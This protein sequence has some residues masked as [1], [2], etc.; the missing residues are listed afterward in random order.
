[1]LPLCSLNQWGN[2]GSETWSDLSSSYSN[3]RQSQD[4]NP[5]Q[6]GTKSKSLSHC[7]TLQRIG[8]HCDTKTA[9]GPQSDFW[10]GVLLW[11]CP[12]FSSSTPCQQDTGMEG[13]SVMAAM[14]IYRAMAWSTFRIHFCVKSQVEKNVCFDLDYP[15]SRLGDKDL[16]TSSLFECDPGKLVR[17]WE[18]EIGG[19][20]SQ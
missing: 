18:S 5:D 17:L 2:Q 16:S 12:D 20:G 9:S 11:D 7:P 19:K 15:R 6:P 10:W 1:M 3:S 13:A 14:L 8:V 4:P